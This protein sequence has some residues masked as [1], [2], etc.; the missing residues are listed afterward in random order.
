MKIDKYNE[1]WKADYELMGKY[2]P[3][4]SSEEKDVYV[5]KKHEYQLKYNF[6]HMEFFSFNLGRM[7]KEGREESISEFYPRKEQAELYYKVNKKEIMELCL[8]KY[9]SYLR[10]KKYYKRKACAYNPNPNEFVKSY[11]DGYDWKCDISTFLEEHSSYIVKPLDGN[12]GI[13]I[14]IVKD[15]SITLENLLE[16]YPGGFILEELLEQVDELAKFHPKSI[17]TVRIETYNTG[18][19]ILIK[20]PCLRVGRG[21]S[22]VDNAHSGGIFAAINPDTGIVL[23]AISSDAVIYEKHPDTNIKFN[24]YKIPQ[25]DEVCKVAKDIAKELPGLTISG[26]DFSLTDKGW[27]LIEI[28]YNPHII[29][30]EATQKG[31]RK[32]IEDFLETISVK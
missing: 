2:Y 4:L 20:H 15:G 16:D 12:S 24:G 13:G 21:D 11:Y 14:R 3:D 10:L 1:F 26:M 25:W 7:I 31:I 30:Q 6:A 23:S 28:N 9:A 27:K 19:D 29:Y 8:D 32:E 18:N 22:I 5:A 17:N